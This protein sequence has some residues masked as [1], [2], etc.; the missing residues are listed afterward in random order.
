[1]RVGGNIFSE[2]ELHSDR[3]F[4]DVSLFSYAGLRATYEKHFLVLRFCFFA[5]FVLAC[6]GVS[7]SEHIRLMDE[8]VSALLVYCKIELGFFALR[9]PSI[10]A[11]GGMI[12]CKI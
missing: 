5:F 9:G 11:R 2:R 3:E 7:I 12:A 4:L 10:L 1:M 8:S 6:L